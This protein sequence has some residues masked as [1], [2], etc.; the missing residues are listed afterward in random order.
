M[1]TIL[2]ECDATEYEV[3]PPKEN[4]TNC[5]ALNDQAVIINLLD[6]NEKVITQTEID[7]ADAIELARLILLK[8]T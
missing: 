6:K 1:S 2:F 3:I 5:F 7:K 8:Y 4:I